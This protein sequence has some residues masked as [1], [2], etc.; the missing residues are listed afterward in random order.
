MKA[1]VSSQKG[2]FLK[3]QLESGDFMNIHQSEFEEPVKVGDL[4]LVTVKKIKE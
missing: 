1:V 2:E 3:C 4:L